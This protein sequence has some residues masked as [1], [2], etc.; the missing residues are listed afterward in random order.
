MSRSPS[1]AVGFLGHTSGALCFSLNSF[2]FRNRKKS[3]A[4]N[5]LWLSEESHYSFSVLHY[6]FT[7]NRLYFALLE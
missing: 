4:L 7:H 2:V 3:D 1:I 5:E 6:G